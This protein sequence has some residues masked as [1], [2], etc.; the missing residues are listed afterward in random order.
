MSVFFKQYKS[1]TVPS[2]LEADFR[3]ERN[4]ENRRVMVFI[5]VLTILFAAVYMIRYRFFPDSGMSEELKAL[6]YRID[7]LLI[8]NGV[9]TILTMKLIHNRKLLRFLTLFWLSLLFILVELVSFI[10]FQTGKDYSSLILVLLMVG[11]F[12]RFSSRARWFFFGGTFL[13][14]DT[15]MLV[16]NPYL[17]TEPVDT[18]FLLIFWSL[19]FYISCRRENERIEYFN[20]RQE[21]VV[22]KDHWKNRSYTDI[23]TGLYNR[24]YFQET[25]NYLWEGSVRYHRGFSLAL[26]DI[27]RFKKVNDTLGHDRG[28]KVLIGIS[29]ILQENSRKSDIITRY[30]GEEFCILLTDTDLKGASIQMNRLREIIGKHSFPNV[31]W[32]IT[33][34]IGIAYSEEVKTP[35]QLSQR[36]DHR[37]YISKHE[38]RNRVTTEGIS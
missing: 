29:R 2:H 38:G 10:D 27:D 12:Y 34:S 32:N 6:H 1:I 37:L 24:G 23:L 17:Q 7:L 28:D 3:E 30:G 4:K 19:G 31:P 9:C 8:A 18:L 25:L 13:I 20:V 14:L 33:V 16:F 22:Q 21:L 36:A 5:S 26:I 11:S 35:R 15:A